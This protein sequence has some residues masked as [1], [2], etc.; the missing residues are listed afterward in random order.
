MDL[1]SSILNSFL[2]YKPKICGYVAVKTHETLS[3]S[4]GAQN[5]LF[6]PKDESRVKENISALDTAKARFM[7]FPSPLI[8][9][10]LGINT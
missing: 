10:D 2:R 1:T 5:V 8:P 4:R 9:A 7:G 3:Q 6:H